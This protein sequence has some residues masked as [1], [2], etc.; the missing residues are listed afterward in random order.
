MNG[1]YIKPF[2]PAITGKYNYNNRMAK[3]KL[4]PGESPTI[5]LPKALKP[6]DKRNYCPQNQ[7]FEG[8]TQF[9]S[10]LSPPYKNIPV[11]IKQDFGRKKRS[12]EMMKTLDNITKQSCLSAE[13]RSPE[14]S[15]VSD[16]TS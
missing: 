5:E 14:I 1:N 6:N 2:D 13:P 8:Y 3:T 9:P 12:M 11:E 7:M 16:I 10:P 4:Q 15:K